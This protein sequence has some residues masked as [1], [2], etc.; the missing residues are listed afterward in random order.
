MPRMLKSRRLI[1]FVIILGVYALVNAFVFSYGSTALSHFPIVQRIF[2]GIFWT[3]A[4]L[5]IVARIVE[6]SYKN[7]F[8]SLILWIGSFWLAMLTYLVLSI[9]VILLISGILGYLAPNLTEIYLA[10]LPFAL[11]CIFLGS[12]LLSASG[13]RN[14]RHAVIRKLEYVFPRGSG[15]GGVFHIVAATDIHLG[16]IIGKKRFGYFIRDVNA[17]K[18]DAIFFVGDTIDEDIEPVIKQDIGTSIRKLHAPLGVFA[19]NGNHEH[20][21]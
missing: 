12:F 8:V 17:L 15:K 5:F 16:T 2:T 7:R 6:R 1:F 19:V 18:P 14:A 9:S 11:L 21:G 3:I 20:I 4:P 13:W 10:H